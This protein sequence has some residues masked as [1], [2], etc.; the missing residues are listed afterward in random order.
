L[1]LSSEVQILP[2]EAA[3]S[4]HGTLLLEE[5]GRTYWITMKEPFLNHERHLQLSRSGFMCEGKS[6]IT[7]D[8]ITCSTDED[9]RQSMQ[10]TV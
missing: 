1:K 7:Q 4:L 8:F 6:I 2:Y 3:Q 5:Q 9:G 10:L